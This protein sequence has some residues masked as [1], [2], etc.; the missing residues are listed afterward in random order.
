M[1]NLRHNAKRVQRPPQQQ[2]GAALI[3]ALVLLLVMTI[4]GVSTMS[5]AVM[6]TQMAANNLFSENAFQLAETGLDN[7]LAQLNASTLTS[8]A[9]TVPNNCDAP[10]APVPIANLGGTY[11]STLCFT[12]DIPHI[13]SSGGSSIGKIRAYHFQNNTQGIA[14]GQASSMH[15]L[16]MRLLGPDGT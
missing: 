13:T 11:Q 8:P 5:T 9:A 6:E 15:S 10:L 14:Q 7:G 12:G 2:S 1:K 3:V 4:L 16:G